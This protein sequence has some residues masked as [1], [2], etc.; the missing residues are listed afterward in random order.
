MARTNARTGKGTKIGYASEELGSP[1]YLLEVVDIPSV[2]ESSGGSVEATHYESQNDATEKLPTGWHET[3]ECSYVC[4]YLSDQVTT[5]MGL[6]QVAKYWTILASN[7]AKWRGYGWISKVGG[8]V[9]NKDKMTSTVTITFSGDLTY[10]AA[11]AGQLVADYTLSLAA[12]VGSIDLTSVDGVDGTGLKV[13]RFEA[14]AKLGNA[15]AVT[16]QEGSANGYAL[17]STI[18]L[19]A[20]QRATILGNDATPDVAAGDKILDVSGTGTDQVE[21]YIIMW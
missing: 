10:V 8:T 17:D 5:L 19:A 3:G 1:S 13:Q 9:P 12:G 4:N 21:L 18:V 2:P 16:I 14:Y 6:R 20:G 7:G 15:G 11:A